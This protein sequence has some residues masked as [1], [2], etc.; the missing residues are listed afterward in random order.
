MYSNLSK[1]TIHRLL[2]DIKQL[3]TNP[4]DKHGIYY[5]HSES[6]LL[7]GTALIFGPSNTPYKFGNFIFDFTFPVDYPFRPP[8]VT[9]VTSDGHTRFNPNLYVNG[10]VCLSILNTWRGEQWSGCQTISSV[11]LSLV[12]IFNDKPLLNEPGVT[13]THVDYHKYN[14]IIKYKTQEIA[15]YKFLKD[16]TDSIFY[17]E[18]RD[19]FLKNYSAICD[20]IKSHRTKNISLISTSIYG[21]TIKIDYDNLLKNLASF[22]QNIQMEKIELNKLNI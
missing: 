8:K 3:Q 22:Y 21:M 6:N 12:S 16:S 1:T 2:S 17:N 9:F 7:K 4:L 10:K 18:A 19:N 11:L 14:E 5:V 15:I 13:E 20:D